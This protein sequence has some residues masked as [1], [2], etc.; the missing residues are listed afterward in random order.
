LDTRYEFNAFKPYEDAT[1]G[2]QGNTAAFLVLVGAP[3]V[4]I[5]LDRAQKKWC[6]I[7]FGALA[8]LIMVHLIIV[9]SRTAFVAWLAVVLLVLFFQR[10][11][12]ISVLSVGTVIIGM[13]YLVP[14]DAAGE[15]LKRMG[16]AVRF[17][18]EHDLSA[19]GRVDAMRIGWQVFKD[20]WVTGVG[21]SAMHFYS[22]YD[23]AHQ[24]FIEQGAEVGVL[25][26]LATVFLVVIVAFRLF[27]IL[28][29]GPNTPA[30][31]MRFLFCIGPFAYLLY[32]LLAN[33]V[34]NITTI[35]TWICLTAAMLAMVDSRFVEQSAAF[36]TFTGKHRRKAALRFRRPSAPV[37]VRTVGKP[38]LAVE[39]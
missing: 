39:E 37:A 13:F 21:P 17:D 27:Q 26:L 24:F 28:R 15:F 34:V 20:H 14:S 36:R 12:G 3:M 38:L 10:R 5:A 8:G 7:W 1:F 19:A 25:G 32:G 30:N 9:Q 18:T 11:V 4:A 35:N 31:R 6:R 23:T 22:P 29:K 16:W 2:N 33:V